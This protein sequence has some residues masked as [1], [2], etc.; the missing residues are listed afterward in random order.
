M[1]PDHNSDSLDLDNRLLRQSLEQ[2][3]LVHIQPDADPKITNEFL[4][5]VAEMEEA[6]SGPHV[7]IRSKLPTD[8]ELPPANVLSDADL[9][10][11]LT[12]LVS[13]L[14]ES[15]IFL[16]L[17]ADLPERET[18]HYLVSEALDEEVPLLTPTGSN[19]TIDGCGGWCEGCFQL[20][21]CDVGQENQSECRT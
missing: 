5:D 15:G 17:V 21:W 4:N 9:S 2:G 8:L 14:A 7:S 3:G 13:T 6:L 10:A 11:T 16:G 20:R 19:Y 12:R 18:Y 1:E